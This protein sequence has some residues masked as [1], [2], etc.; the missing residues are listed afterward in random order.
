[1][2]WTIPTFGIYHLFL[3]SNVNREARDL[4]HAEGV[5]AL[6]DNPADAQ[7]S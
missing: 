5:S 3:W 4:G 6:A 7:R 2:G 1:M